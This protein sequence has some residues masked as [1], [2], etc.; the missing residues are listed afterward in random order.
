MPALYSASVDGATNAP[1]VNQKN[2][3]EVVLDIDVV[4]SVAQGANI[5]VYFTLDTQQG[6]ID[7]V[8]QIVH[9]PDLPL[10][11]SP[12]SV[13]SCSWG[14]A[15]NTPNGFDVDWTQGAVAAMTETFHEATM[16][17]IT[18]FMTSGDQGSDCGV[19]DGNAHVEYPASDQWVT[20]CGGTTIVN[21]AGPSCGQL[22]WNYQGATGGG[23]S[24]IVDLPPYQQGAGIPPSLSTGNPGRIGRGVPDIAGYACL[25]YNITVWGQSQPVGGTSAVAPLY[26]AYIALLNANSGGN[27]GFLNPQLYQFRG[28]SIFRDI[29]DG[30]NNSFNGAPGYTSVPGWD[31]CTGLGTLD[32]AAFRTLFSG[33]FSIGNCSLLESTFRADSGKPYN[34]EAMLLQGNQ[35]FHVW[36]DNSDPSLSWHVGAVVSQAATADACIIESDYRSGSGNPGNFEILV[37]EGNNIVHYWRNNSDPSEPWSSSAVVSTQAS[38]SACMIEGTFRADGSKPGN[39]EALIL[40]GNNIVHYWRDNSASGTPW[41]RGLVVSSQATGPACIIEGTFRADGSKPG[42]FEALILE[43]NNIVHYWRDNSA[44]GTPWHRGLVVS[45]QATG[46]ACMIEGTFRADGSKPGNFEALILEGN[47]IVHYWRDNSASGTPWHRGLVVS[48]QATGPACMIE[49]TFRADGSKPGNF[50]VLVSAA[51]PP[52]IGQALH[53]WRDNSAAD[54][55]WHQGIGVV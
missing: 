45:S 42:N 6:W 14:Y 39:F 46:P 22:T 29:A 1:G 18:V 15:E 31:A 34:F 47:N 40:E 36:R 17:L 38:G 26:A 49:G 11:W 52:S 19:G 7:A 12:P 24:D 28:T 23:I 21:V 16:F 50:E 33:G 27:F 54:L 32:G 51:L 4:G 8:T 41:H 37:L 3:S 48:S 2:D 35:L 10:D 44:S 55:A 5:A 13:I 43:G 25:G 30:A 9:E 53:F 20:S